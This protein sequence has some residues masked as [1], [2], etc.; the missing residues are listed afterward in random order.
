MA[1]GGLLLPLL[2]RG[3]RPRRDFSLASARDTYMPKGI[4]YMHIYYL[5]GVTKAMEPLFCN[6]QLDSTGAPTGASYLRKNPAMA[7][8]EGLH[9]GML[10]LDIVAIFI[11]CVLCPLTYLYVFFRL[12]PK[13]GLNN[14]RLVHLYGF[15]WSRFEPDSYWWEAIELIRKFGV[16]LVVALV[17]HA[18]PQ[19]LGAV[20]LVLIVF[21]VSLVK[22]PFIRGIYDFYDK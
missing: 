22:Q 5:S 1:M 6:P 16:V 8:Y 12:V 17:P 15:L 4:L 19:S 3:W 18:M 14:P 21:I 20:V 7:C 10:A 2:A 11:Y 13:R 9:A